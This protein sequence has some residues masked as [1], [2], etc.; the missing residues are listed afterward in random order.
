MLKEGWLW[1]LGSRLL[2]LWLGASVRPA[3][4]G[5]VLVMP[6]EGSHWLS[7]K[8]LATELAGRGH[9]ILV[10]VPETNLLIRSSELFRTETFP[11]RISKEQLSTSLNGF[12]QGVF[13]RSPALF[14]IFVQMERLMNFTETQVQ[15]C[16]SLLYNEPLMEKLKEENFELVLTDPFLPCG[17]I[18]A[19]KLGLPAVYFLRGMPCG[20]DMLASQCPSPPSY[21]PRFHSGST[22]SM[23]FGERVRNFLMSG[24][25]MGLCKIMYASF[26]E[27]AA[28]YLDEDVT[29]QELIGR[30]AVWLLRYDFTF[31]Y[32]R[33]LMP[34]MFLIGGINCAKTSKLTAV[35]RRK[36]FWICH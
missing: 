33:P 27:L 21:V 36:C 1:G 23:T 12:Q 20:L 26:D 15:G 14:D 34:N 18:I 19:A 10:L 3:Q 9:D 8:V 32:P 28:R 31:E 22:D 4:G 24:T 2:L 35:S 7:M 13:T 25:E 17:A 6:V 30:G 16:E 29:Y 5:R 11:V